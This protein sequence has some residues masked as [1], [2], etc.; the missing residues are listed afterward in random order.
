M[1]TIYFDMDGTIANLYGVNNWLDKLINKDES[2]YRDAKPLLRL[3]TLARVLNTLQRKGHK[4]GIV[5]WLAKN[6]NADYDMRV[7]EAKMEWLGTH[8]KS[9]QFDEI[10][11]VEYGTPKHNIVKDKNGILFDDEEKNRINWTGTA[12]DVDNIIE[13][14]KAIAQRLLFRV[15]SLDVIRL[16][17]KFSENGKKGLTFLFKYDNINTTREIK[18]D[19]P[20]TVT[21]KAVTVNRQ[22]DEVRQSQMVRPTR[23]SKTKPMNRPQ[24]SRRCGI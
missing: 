11:I 8:L 1:K 4:I 13:V 15:I 14:L 6:S 12:Y 19:A 3:C 18:S 24:G 17:K 2:P 23:V 10:H 7:T 20:Q 21:L 16:R 5:S 22:N 9:V